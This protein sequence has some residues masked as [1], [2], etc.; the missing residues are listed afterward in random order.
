MLEESSWGV[1]K[2]RTVRRLRIPERS[3][4]NLSRLTLL[5][6]ESTLPDMDTKP[7]SAHWEKPN[8]PTGHAQ[9]HVRGTGSPPSRLLRVAAWLQAARLPAQLYIF[10][11]LL[12]GQSLATAQGMS[13]SWSAL[14]ACQGYGL[15]MQLFIVFANDVADKETDALNR[16]ATPFSGGSRVLVNGVLTPE[17]LGRAALACAMVCLLLGLVLRVLSGTWTP[18]L[19]ILTGLGL[20]W[21]Y[22]FRPLR[23]SYRGGGEILQMFGV[24]TILPLIGYSAQ[25]GGLTGMD[26][27]MLGPLLP[28]SL[29]CAMSTALPDAPSDAQSA[30]RT[31]AVVFGVRTAQDLILVLNILALGLFTAWAFRGAYAGM[32]LAQGPLIPGMVLGV[33]A[34]ILLAAWRMRHP[35]PG[36]LAMSWFV[37]LQIIFFLAPVIGLT[38]LLLRS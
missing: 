1:Q 4:A 33:W 29:A 10:W 7:A 26:W 20:L 28:L 21:A 16:T 23:L 12:L 37:A 19:L 17:E 18:S 24:G 15:A 31:S 22:S 25:S 3:L 5:Q 8:K 38:A 14:L 32:I 2:Y 34:A 6:A 36:T 9:S 27:T 35:R 11:P 13:L 30:K